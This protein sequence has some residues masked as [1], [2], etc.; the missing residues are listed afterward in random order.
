[1]DTPKWLVIVPPLKEKIKLD[2]KDNRLYF[3]N[4]RDNL[5]GYL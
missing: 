2:F 3:N 1:M 5:K 4:C